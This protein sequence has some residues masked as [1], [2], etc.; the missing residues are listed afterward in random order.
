[1]KLALL[2]YG[3]MGQTIERVAKESGHDVVCIFDIDREE[4]INGAEVRGELAPELLGVGYLIGP[5]IACLMMAGAVLSYFVLGPAIATFGAKLDEP[6]A[7]AKRNAHRLDVVAQHPRLADRLRRLIF[8]FASL[9]NHRNYFTR[10]KRQ[11]AGN[12]GS[13]H[14]RQ[15]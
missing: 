7:P 15:I 3:K 12:P 4:P 9:D 6:V 1:M 2:G 10:I 14:A 13:P 5:R 8:T 11:I